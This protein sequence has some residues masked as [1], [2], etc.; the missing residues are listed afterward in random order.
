MALNLSLN[1]EPDMTEVLLIK[2][3]GSAYL[4]ELIKF[5]FFFFFFFFFFFCVVTRCFITFIA[6]VCFFAVT[7]R[8]NVIHGLWVMSTGQVLNV[9]T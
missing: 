8:M 6:P 4:M 9:D 5:I 7:R 2:L 1:V 3:E